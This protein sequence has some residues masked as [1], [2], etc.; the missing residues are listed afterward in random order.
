MQLL[1]GICAI[2]LV[3]TFT[4]PAN[5]A[6][7]F[8]PKA[9]AIQPASDVL[10]IRDGARWHRNYRRGGWHNGRRG[11]R[12]YGGGY[13]DYNGLWYPGGAFIAGAIIGSAIANSNNYYGDYNN[14]YYGRRYYEDRYYPRRYYPERYYRQYYS[15][16]LP[17]SPRLDDAG[18]C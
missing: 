14:R 9:Q 6:P 10:N 5:A 12:H 1:P 17:C 7:I 16:E 4:L 8:L 13:G 11:Y 3:A 2:A 18:M 15:N